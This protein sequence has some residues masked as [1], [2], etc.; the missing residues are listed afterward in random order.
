MNADTISLPPMDFEL[1]RYD[2]SKVNVKRLTKILKA[3]WSKVDDS[4]RIYLSNYASFM[5]KLNFVLQY[6]PLSEEQNGELNDLRDWVLEYVQKCQ[7]YNEIWDALAIVTER[8]L[9]E[10]VKPLMEKYEP[11]PE[12]CSVTFTVLES[13]LTLWH[14]P[15]FCG[16]QGNIAEALLTLFAFN[17]DG[18]LPGYSFKDPT[19]W[20][21]ETIFPSGGQKL[22]ERKNEVS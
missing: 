2:G 12:N 14:H 17:K 4:T 21:T 11:E 20:E 8:Q 5:A 7:G 3:L 6:V 18:E 19:L 13:A 1:K 16:A 22:K 9:E 15:V 10:V